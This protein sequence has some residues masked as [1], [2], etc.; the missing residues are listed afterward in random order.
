MVKALAIYPG[1]FD[2]VTNG[3]IDLIKRGLRIFG[4]MIVSVVTN[5]SKK[6][7]FTLEERVEML[8]EVTSEMEGRVEIESFDGLLVHYMRERGANVVLRGLRAVSD[9]EYELE[10]ALTNRQLDSTVETVF[11]TPS[12]EYVYLRAST[13]KTIAS[14]GGDVSAFVPAVVEKRL[15]ERFTHK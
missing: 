8:R 12:V 1:S 9:F 5:P 15:L 10:M 7:L 14:R 3:H 6:P 4:N 2:P 11:L 13:V